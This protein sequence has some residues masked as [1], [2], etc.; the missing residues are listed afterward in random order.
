MFR[1]H[2]DRSSAGMLSHRP[3]NGLAFPR[4]AAVAASVRK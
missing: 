3:S 1:E 4:V 2:A